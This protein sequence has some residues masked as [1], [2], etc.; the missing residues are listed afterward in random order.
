MVWRDLD[1]GVDAPGITAADAWSAMRPLITDDRCIRLHYE[2]ES[3]LGSSDARHYFVCRLAAE[4][5][6]EWKLDISI[7]TNGVPP[8]VEPFQASLAE[9]LGDDLRLVILRLKEGWWRDPAY[10]DLV[11]GFEIYDAV[12]DHGVRTLA[13]LDAYLRERGFPTRS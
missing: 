1:F 8:E 6:H 13:E 7:W 4:T 9:R 3:A 5:G 10:P 2:N 12:L 11:G